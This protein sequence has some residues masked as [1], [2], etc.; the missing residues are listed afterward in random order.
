MAATR[1][2]DRTVASIKTAESGRLELW[3]TDLRTLSPRFGTFES[4]GLSL[5]PP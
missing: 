2:T 3:D 5:P 1:L 4:L